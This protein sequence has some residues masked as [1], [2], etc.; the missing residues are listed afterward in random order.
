[1]GAEL[2]PEYRLD[3]EKA[4]DR[5]SEQRERGWRMGCRA[6]QGWAEGTVARWKKAKCGSGGL[7]AK[8]SS[9]TGKLGDFG[10]GHLTSE[11]QGLLL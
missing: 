11:S 10:G 8:P 1:M 2:F 6:G 9:T 3:S 5:L 7:S 4:Q